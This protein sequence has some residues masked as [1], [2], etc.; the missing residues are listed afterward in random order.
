[1][2]PPPPFTTTWGMVLIIAMAY[3]ALFATFLWAAG[4]WV[5]M[6][7]S[8]I[9]EWENWA[10]ER[11]QVLLSTNVAIAMM[12]MLRIERIGA[13]CG[14][15]MGFFVGGINGILVRSVSIQKHQ[16]TVKRILQ[17]AARA[18]KSASAGASVD[19]KAEGAVEA[20]AT[21][22]AGGARDDHPKEE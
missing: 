1:M 3:A 10:L 20:S 8:S 14:F 12:P 13:L 21:E 5:F 4:L 17:E 11:I 9:Q 18:A 22:A 2:V 15:G 7:N 19:A 16:E 6:E